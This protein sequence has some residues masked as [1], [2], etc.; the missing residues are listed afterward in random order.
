MCVCDTFLCAVLVQLPRVSSAAGC[1]PCRLSEKRLRL[2]GEDGVGEKGRMDGLPFS[3]SPCMHSLGGVD[4]SGLRMKA[5][6]ECKGDG[7]VAGAG[8]GGGG[9]NAHMG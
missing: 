8:W 4:V 9:D 1:H 7:E 5:R 3:P 2:E 6:G